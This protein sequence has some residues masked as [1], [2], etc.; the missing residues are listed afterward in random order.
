MGECGGA[1]TRQ[2]SGSSLLPRRVGRVH[3]AS[4]SRTY[5]V[6]VLR[7]ITLPISHYCEKARWALERAGIGYRE[8]RHVQGIHQFAARRAGGA[9]TVPVLVTPDGA[10]GESAEILAWVDERTPSAHRLLPADPA[11]R[12]DVGRLCR[13]LDEGLGP[14]GRRLLY[15]HMF[16]QSKLALR[17]YN[18]GVPHWEDRA[19]RLGWPL[20]KGFVKRELGIHPASEADDEAAVFSEFDYVAER[21]ADGRPHLCGELMATQATDK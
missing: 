9:K 17:F 20:A 16:T 15:I 3:E 11:A 6:V 10:I 12:D 2:T 13:R 4:A 5:S 7:L 8:E 1:P 21:L 18:Q 14:D 19:I